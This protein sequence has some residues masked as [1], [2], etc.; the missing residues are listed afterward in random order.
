[1]K[2]LKLI[3]KNALRHKL[4]SVLTALGIA[5]AV[6]AFGILRTV[7]D[8][9]YIGVEASSQTR[10]I[11]RNKVSLGFPMPIS[12]REKI[13]QIPGVTGIA[14][15]QWFGG[16]YIDAKNFFAR[17]AVEPESFLELYPE[18]VL[19]AK[20]KEDFLRER[21][22]CIVGAKIAAKYGWKL[23]DSIRLIGDIFPG[24]W[25]FV[26]RGIYHGADRT[27]D[28][29]Q[30]FFHWK[31][32][33]EQLGLTT[34]GRMGQVGFFYVGV[35]SA[36]DVVRVA[37]AID[38]MFVN[39]MAETKTET[40]KEF[41][42]SFV[43]MVGTI[44]TTVRVISV[45]VIAIILLVLANTMAMTARERVTE[46]AVL[47]TLGFRPGHLSGLIFGE[48]LF[49]AILGG[50]VG[51]LLSFPIIDKFGEFLSVNLGSFFPVFE[52]SRSTV[53][54]AAAA[55]LLVGVAAAVFPTFK[56]TRMRI[57]DGLRYIG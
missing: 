46:Y 49:I 54:I 48:S 5:I 12:Y 2:I 37:E 32:L 4:R 19:S 36:D 1:M 52:L 20:E 7:I 55:A 23:G 39:S 56:A 50:V 42:M 21:N 6:L 38:A 31:Y 35:A 14:I 34:P 11:T 24:D 18:Y 13:A 17:F 51:L 27:T 47:K 43:S 33:D 44:I 40:E 16:V 3:F 25:D 15:G 29:T 28:E 8:A 41:Q 10:L 9:W 22:S 30:M 26:I 45:V 53:F 57:A